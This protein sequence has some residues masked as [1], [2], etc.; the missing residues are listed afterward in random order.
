MRLLILFG[1]WYFLH[2][3]TGRY[4]PT[5]AQPILL[6]THRILAANSL[7]IAAPL[8]CFLIHQDHLK[9]ILPL[10]AS[11]KVAIVRINEDLPAPFG[12]SSPNSPLLILSV[13]LF[14]ARIPFEYVLHKLLIWSSIVLGLK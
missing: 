1:E 5:A 3:S 12:P 2:L 6:D 13:I 11:C 4:G 14:R 9:K 8:S 7:I 10:S